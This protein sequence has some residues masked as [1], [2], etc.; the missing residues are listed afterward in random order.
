MTDG[1]T[2]VE[3]L[4]KNRIRGLRL[5]E[6]AR[7]DPRTPLSETLSL[8]RSGKVGCALVCDGDQ[9]VGIF[10]ER[11]VLKSLLGPGPNYAAPVEQFMTSRPQTLTLNDTLGAALRMMIGNGF[12]HVPVLDE[13]GRTVHAMS[14]RDLIVY[15]AEHFPAEV[16]NL[17]PRLHQVMRK[18]EGG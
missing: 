4:Q 10:T 11:D 9:I 18:P 3:A 6:P 13:E 15:I 16:V 12:R 14:A 2:F 17:P 1:L 5:A 7:V 8:M